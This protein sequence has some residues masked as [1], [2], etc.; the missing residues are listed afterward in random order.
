VL[1]LE[2]PFGL[3]FIFFGTLTHVI[4]VQGV[5]IGALVLA[6]ILLQALPL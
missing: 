1:E 3:G 6:G 4:H 2:S 5:N